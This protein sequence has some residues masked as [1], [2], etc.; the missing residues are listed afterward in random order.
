MEYENY[1]YHKKTIKEMEL[2]LDNTKLKIA[3]DFKDL[4]KDQFNM[5]LT[6][7]DNRDDMI[8]EIMNK[9]ILNSSE[10]IYE[11]ALKKFKTT[12]RAKKFDKM[13][14]NNN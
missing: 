3:N 14:V 5:S 1:V 6:N 2:K 9:Q 8:N 10:E 11:T 12:V 7:V 4:L 13:F